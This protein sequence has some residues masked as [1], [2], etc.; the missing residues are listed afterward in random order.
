[1][2]VVFARVL[3]NP[4]LCQDLSDHRNTPREVVGNLMTSVPFEGTQALRCLVL[5]H[6]LLPCAP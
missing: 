3:G 4:H 5:G 6:S 1:M 2:P